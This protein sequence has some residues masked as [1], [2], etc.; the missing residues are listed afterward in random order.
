MMT[1]QT[2]LTAIDAQPN[3]AAPAS[4]PQ[5]TIRECVE[6]CMR[7]YFGNLDGQAACD[8]YDMVLAEVEQPLLEVVLNYTRDNQSKAAEVLGLNRGTLRKKLKQYDLL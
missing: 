7:N 8:V 1:D 2:T 4:A 5:E 3:T 6:R